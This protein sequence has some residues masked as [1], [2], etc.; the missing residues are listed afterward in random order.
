MEGY[1]FSYIRFSQGSLPNAIFIGEL[2]SLLARG[3][4]GGNGVWEV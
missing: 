4:R 1:K 2:L 3:G